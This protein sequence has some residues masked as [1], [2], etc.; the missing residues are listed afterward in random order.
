M[1]ISGIM[2]ARAGIETRGH[3]L[4]AIQREMAEQR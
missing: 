2:V 1:A 3:A 4:E